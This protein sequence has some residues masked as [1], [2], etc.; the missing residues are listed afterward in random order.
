[1]PA[2]AAEVPQVALQAL[3]NNPNVAR[4][5]LDT[6]V[7]EVDAELDAAWGVKRIG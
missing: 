6:V 7:S 4:I 1:M 2:I 5:T 3:G